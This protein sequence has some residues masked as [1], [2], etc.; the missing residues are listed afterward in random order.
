MDAPTSAKMLT[1]L[2]DLWSRIDS[3][4]RA[5]LRQDLYERWFSPLRPIALGDG[6]LQIG[7]PDRF[8]R[9]FV[10]DHYRSLF[11]DCVPSLVG[12]RIRIVFAVDDAPRP[13][14]SPSAAAPA[15]TPS[16][17]PAL[18]PVPL[19]RTDGGPIDPRDSRP[20][21]RYAFDTFVVGAS[22]HFAFA[23]AQAVAANPGRTWNPLF[24]HGDSGLGKTHLLH[25]VA[26]A[27]LEKSGGRVAIV[28]SER[29]TNDFVAALSKGTMDEFRRKYR[30]CSALLVDDVQFLA[31]KDKTAEEFFHTFNELHDHHVQIVLSSDRSP[32]ELKGL[33]ERLCSRFEWGMRVQIEAPEFETRAAIL[34]KKADVETIDLPDEVTQLLAQHIRS[35][36]RELEGAL[37]RLAAFASL[38]SEPITI[39]L[40][41]DVLSDVIPPEGYRPSIER[42][43]EEV[44][45]YYG[46]TV[47]K[48]TSASREQ[49]IALP[50]QV[51]MWLCRELAKETLQSIAEKFNKK[52]HTTVISAIERVNTLR[53]T[54]EGVKG[55]LRALTSKLAP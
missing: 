35:N 10:E 40:A 43:Q 13:M 42:I 11:E 34:K 9:D 21:P 17:T 23:A 31:G 28:S 50:R 2:D 46:L 1:P 37:M 33:D 45:G 6:R 26:H 18:T 16:S 3:I 38:K 49:K 44:A 41:R 24:L 54:D 48:L 7:A 53:E 5:R 47:A 14:P 12:E 15:L 32:K 4:L 30:E 52:D 8:H 19:P 36:V 25:A 51:A 22:N 27:I 55:A 20:N 39:Q 29:Y